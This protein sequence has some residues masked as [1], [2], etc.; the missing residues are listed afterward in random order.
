M[1]TREI[2]PQVINSLDEKDKKRLMISNKE[3]IVL[4]L[5]IFNAGSFV[6]CK[7]TNDYNRYKNVSNY[8]NCILYLS[9]VIDI[10][11]N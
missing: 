11:N 6:T 3:Y 8:G 4:E 2:L 10:L 9:E 1:I 7:L 5:H